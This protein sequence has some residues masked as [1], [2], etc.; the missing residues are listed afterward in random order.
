[1]I[2]PIMS[3]PIAYPTQL[4]VFWVECQKEGCA[5]WIDTSSGG[6]KRGCCGA[7]D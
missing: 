7:I 3:K 2:C 4:E 6:I 1:M 5:W